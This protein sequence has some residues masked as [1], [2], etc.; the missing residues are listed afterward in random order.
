MYSLQVKGMSYSG[1]TA[2]L[3]CFLSGRLA[4][5]LM[6]LLL[7]AAAVGVAVVVSPPSKSRMNKPSSEFR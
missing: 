7:A 1:S 4:A 6:L 5:T 2:L 3:E